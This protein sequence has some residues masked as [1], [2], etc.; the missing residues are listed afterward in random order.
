MEIDFGC[1]LS[2]LVRRTSLASLPS[3]TDHS[4][5]YFYRRAEGR[6]PGY[7]PEAEVWRV[8]ER[9]HPGRRE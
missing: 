2:L 7:V 3:P 4:L 1:A 8:W 6:E 9:D 5:S